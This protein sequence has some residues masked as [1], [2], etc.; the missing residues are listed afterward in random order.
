MRAMGGEE[1]ER[2][3]YRVMENEETNKDVLVAK[4]VRSWLCTYTPMRMNVHI[5]TASIHT[6]T[7]I[8]I[9]CASECVWRREDFG[10]GGECFPLSA[11]VPRAIAVQ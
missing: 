9:M 2:A 1:Y 10:G 11:Y 8:I 7:H 6:H 5:Y 3:R 4:D